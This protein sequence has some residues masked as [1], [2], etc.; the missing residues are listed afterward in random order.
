MQGDVGLRGFVWG[1]EDLRFSLDIMAYRAYG[2]GL[3]H[4]AESV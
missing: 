2:L 1:T 4:F 3:G